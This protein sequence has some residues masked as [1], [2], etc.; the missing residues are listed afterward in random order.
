MAEVNASINQPEKL[1]VD[2]GQDLTVDLGFSGDLEAV[3]TPFFRPVT[4]SWLQPEFL[5]CSDCPN[6]VASPPTNTSFVVT[7]IDETNC[8]ATD[9]VLFF[10]NPNRPIFI[11]NAFSPNFDGSN[12]QFTIYGGPAAERISELRIFDRWG[13]MVY[14]AIDIPMNEESFGWDGRFNNKDLS[15]GVFTFV[16]K[17]LFID[18]VVETYGGDISLIR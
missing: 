11:P 15:I 13:N 12:D 10:I 17:V 7:I 18:Q 4:F 2:A 9:S 3:T 16:A 5:S 8:T 14:E 6:P 1:T